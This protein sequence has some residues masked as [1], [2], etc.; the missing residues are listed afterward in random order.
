[1][2]PGRLGQTRSIGRSVLL[3]LVTLG[4][5]SLYWTYRTHEEIRLR[6]GHGMGGGTGLLVY[7]CLGIV[8]PFLLAAEV[9][10]MLVGDGRDSRV[11]TRTGWW[12]LLPVAGPFLWFA[13]VQGQL[14]DYWRSLGASG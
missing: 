9:E 3:A 6:S 1:V 7:F 10:T 12:V 14:N 4:L 2:I 8:T 13:K 11:S 5:Y